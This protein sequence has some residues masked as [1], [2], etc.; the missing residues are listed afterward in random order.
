[1]MMIVLKIDFGIQFEQGHE[2][3]RIEM[4]DSEVQNSVLELVWCPCAHLNRSQVQNRFS[5]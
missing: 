4:V 1:M 3:F 2:N 5:L